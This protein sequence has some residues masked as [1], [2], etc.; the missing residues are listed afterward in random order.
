MSQLCGADFPIQ[1]LLNS[2]GSI[3]S[4]YGT[5]NQDETAIEVPGC[6]D[7]L[8]S[9]KEIFKIACEGSIPCFPRSSKIGAWIMGVGSGALTLATYLCLQHLKHCCDSPDN[10]DGDLINMAFFKKDD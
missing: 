10:D 9:K 3:N 1:Q 8:P 4:I 2:E 6:Y 5:T 7:L